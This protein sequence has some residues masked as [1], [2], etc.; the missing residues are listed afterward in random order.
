[1]G[2]AEFTSSTVPVFRHSQSNKPGEV[3]GAESAGSVQ[4]QTTV[5]DE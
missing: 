4:L 2:N 1:M 5:R 3:L